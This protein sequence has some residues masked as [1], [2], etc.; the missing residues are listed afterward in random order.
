[1]ELALCLR[2]LPA[3]VANFEPRTKITL[4]KYYTYSGYLVADEITGVNCRPEWGVATVA[5]RI[6]AH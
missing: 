4:C 2:F 5:T 3:R 1:V 6:H